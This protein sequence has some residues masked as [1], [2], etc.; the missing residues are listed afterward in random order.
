M[1]LSKSRGGLKKGSIMFC[2]KTSQH[3]Q[4][5]QQRELGMVFPP[6]WILFDAPGRHQHGE[7]LESSVPAADGKP[8]PFQLELEFWESQGLSQI[9]FGTPECPGIIPCCCFITADKARWVWE[10]AI[11]GISFCEG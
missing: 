8:E 4:Q 3:H 2:P 9:V 5:Q 11:L 1:K 6:C 10:A 7:L